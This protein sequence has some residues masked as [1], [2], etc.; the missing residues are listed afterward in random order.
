MS[1]LKNKKILITAGPTREAI[2]PVRYISNHSSGK[3]GYA[4]ATEFLR[5]GAKVILISGPVNVQ[6]QHPNLKL[7]SVT[8]AFEMYVASSL[9]F[10]EIDIAV[11]AAAVSD[12]KPE[13]FEKK[14]IKKSGEELFIKLVKNKDIAYEFGKFKNDSQLSIGFAL[15][16]NDEL[17]N[18]ESKL[19]CKNFD[20]VILNSMNDAG[21]TF[22]HDTNKVT[23]ID[24]NLLLQEFP[25]KHKSEVAV[26]II[27]MIAGMVINK[28]F[29]LEGQ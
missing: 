23:M 10:N 15:E 7:I 27:K 29:V 22:E 2:D 17:M 8:S 25:V 6:L 1:I 12:Y 21:A 14:K 19:R 4:I 3:M 18:A 28:Q 13:I 9:H 5:Q 26:D 16:T 11:F 20:M 24:K